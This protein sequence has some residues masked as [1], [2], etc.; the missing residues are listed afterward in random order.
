[1]FYLF[2]YLEWV[3]YHDDKNVFHRYEKLSSKWPQN[4]VALGDTVV[5]TAEL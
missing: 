4:F 1:M 5:S 3:P 2:I